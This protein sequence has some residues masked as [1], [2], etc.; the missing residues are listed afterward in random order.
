MP[1]SI[2]IDPAIAANHGC[3]VKRTG[4]GSIIE[5]GTSAA[6]NRLDRQRKSTN[7]AKWSQHWDGVETRS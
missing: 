3:V 7:G 5:F 2:L 4:K 1:S 6:K